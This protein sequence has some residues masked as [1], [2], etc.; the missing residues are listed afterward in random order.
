MFFVMLYHPNKEIPALP[1]LN[2]ADEICFF[3]YV[4]EAKA[5]A[6]NNELGEHF[7]FD[8]FQLGNGE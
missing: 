2:A 1:M 8:V 5:A 3:D 7:G 4:D 6:K